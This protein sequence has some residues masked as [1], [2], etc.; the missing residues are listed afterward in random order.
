MDEQGKNIII[1]FTE[2][3]EAIYK[4]PGSLTSL[5]VTGEVNVTNSS[6]AHRLWNIMLQLKGLEMVLSDLTPEIK[7]GELPPGGQWSGTYEVKTEEIQTKT[8]LKLT[9]KIDTYYEKGVEVN[10]ALV[11]DHQMPVSFTISLENTTGNTITDIKLTKHLPEPFG[12]PIIDSPDQ[13]NANFDAATRTITWKEFNLIPGGVQS[14]ILRVGFR[15]EQVDPIPTGDI[16][17]N[18]TVP[19]LIRSKLTG[20]TDAHSDSMFAIDQG[21]SL[22]EPGEWECTAEFEN[23]SDFVVSLR[24]VVVNQVMETRKETVIEEVPSIQLLPDGRW[25]KDFKV[26][27]GTVPKFTSLHDFNIVPVITSKIIGHIKYEAGVLPVAHITA[28]KIIDPPSVS[29]YTKTPVKISLVV[30]NA[31][32]ATLNELTLRDTI[33]RDH[34]PPE[35]NE[36]LVYIGDE[37]IH[38]GVIRDMDPNDTNP[39]LQ[40]LLTVKIENLSQAGGF[41]P[42][43]QI[44]VTYPVQSWEPKPKVEYPCPLDVIA[45]VSPPGPPVKIPTLQAAV[46]VKYVRRRISARKGQTPGAEAGEYIIPIIFENKG[47]VLIENITLKDI[48]PLNFSLLDWN[49]KEFAPQTQET[50]RGTVLTWKIDKAEPG[51]RVKFSYTIKGTGDYEREELEV[52]VG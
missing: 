8:S 32:S 42:E 18:Y 23:T 30:T 49:P 34:K 47:E 31:G 36:V 5:K 16:D 26:K 33:P 40:H 44:L 45:N 39:E 12:N 14:L 27:S 35:L 46:E 29:A 1:D 22:D 50:E 48:V 7:I 3:E 28:E 6:N 51:Q 52:I 37:E 21:E 15:P 17:V 41:R 2:K 9:E 25:S 13:G 24:R 10:W 38:N 19:G 43:D 4:P 20:M 11:K